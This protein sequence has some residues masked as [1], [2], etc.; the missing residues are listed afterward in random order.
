MFRADK[1][2]TSFAGL[3]GWR[4]STLSGSDTIT[5]AN[6]ATASGLYFQDTNP[7]LI[8]V[9]NIKST[10]EDTAISAPNLN[11]L[12]T[13]MYVD[14]VNDTLSRVIE[15]RAS[16]FKSYNLYPYE[17]AFSE[18]ITPNGRFVGFRIE[19]YGGMDLLTKINF[20]EL[21]FDAAVTFNVYLFNSNLKTAI[22]TQS[23][24]TVA[25]QSKIQAID[26]NLTDDATYKGGVFYIGYFESDLS[27][28][29]AYD[30]SFER[31]N[32]KVSTS[33]IDIEAVNVGCTGTVLDVEDVEA[34]S[35]SGGLNIGITI[36]TD[37]TE[38]LIRNKTYFA[39]AI[40]LAMAE[41]C[42]ILYKNSMRANRNERLLNAI[43]FELF[44]NPELK[45]EGLNQKLEREINTIRK[46]MFSD[47]PLILGTLS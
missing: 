21:S 36:S 44:G 4:Q 9:N 14:C 41:K 45:I 35:Y 25:G 31:S 20:L 3:V 40:Q 37:F 5:E 24:T 28:A 22:Q 6:L 1:I 47:N 17:K 12:L 32:V 34:Q 16:N 43:D 11:T 8:S 7:G 39:R 10:Q 13:N 26:W 33:I 29:K 23:V 18:T 46:M 19:S 30:R 27:G 38:L 15:N 2:K 42:L